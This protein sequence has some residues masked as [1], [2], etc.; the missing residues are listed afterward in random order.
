MIQ[1]GDIL[2]A[3]SGATT[4]KTGIYNLEQ[5]ALLNQRVGKFEPNLQHIDRAYLKHFVRK[6]TNEVFSKAY[7][8]AQPNISGTM[9]ESV[10]IP[11]PPLSEQKKIVAKLEK[12]LGKAI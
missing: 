12:L 8:M 1:K 9:I 7:G 6:I 3:M 2:I 11:V 10:E 4:G 5:D